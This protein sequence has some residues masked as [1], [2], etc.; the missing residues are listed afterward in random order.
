[1][2]RLLSIFVFG[3]FGLASHSTM[4][5][6]AE[7]RFALVIGNSAYKVGSRPTPV[8]DSGLIAQALKETGFQVTAQNDLNEEQLRKTFGDFAARIGK[9]G[10]DAVA[11]VYFAGNGLQ[12]RGENYLLPVDAGVASV[13]DARAHA[14]SLSEQMHAF[15]ALHLKASIF[16]VDEAGISPS[17]WSGSP[18]AGGFAWVEPEP[19]MLVAFNAAPGTA[20]GEATESAGSYAKV[21]AELIRG[22]SLTPA[23]LFGQVRLRV[24]E[25]TMGAEVPWSAS[26]IPP[27]FVLFARKSDAPARTDR[28]AFLAS[29]R[30]QPL[31]K[32]GVRNAYLV[33]LLRDTLDGYADFLADY[34]QDPMAR[35]VQALLAARREAITWWRSYQRN[36]PEAYWTYLERY[37]NGPHA[38]DAHGLLSRL[39]A[40]NDPPTRFAKL[41]YDVPPPLPDELAY[42]KRPGL[43]LDDPQLA[44]APPPPLPTDVQPQPPQPAM[45]KSPA[46]AAPAGGEPNPGIGPAPLSPLV[47]GNV[48]AALDIT[49][50]IGR[51][52]SPSEK[53]IMPPG[54]PHDVTRGGGEGAASP[55][56]PGSAP[57]GSVKVDQ[58]PVDE[59]S[60]TGGPGPMA[61]ADKAADLAPATATMPIPATPTRAQDRM[62]AALAPSTSLPIPLR[63]PAS[64][65]ARVPVAGV[66]SQAGPAA[67]N[68]SPTAAKP[69]LAPRPNPQ[70]KL[71]VEGAAAPRPPQA[72]GA[73]KPT[74]TR[75]PQSGC[76]DLDG[77]QD[78]PGKRTCR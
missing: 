61:P 47:P 73:A 62:P 50:A 77:R 32:I 49:G 46:S 42:L 15:A 20:I 65:P 76:T 17:S 40:S 28:L 70:P 74:A 8:N 9:G 2:Q 5:V 12:L 6:A 66:P 48:P 4:A 29:L 3:F 53:S 14:V 36:V 34:W 7:M 16:I 26:K 59:R 56:Q 11:V 25:L 63:R 22:D 13:D 35:R 60:A 18:P 37:P 54:S 64:A 44:F 75:Q 41:E 27:Q 57:S 30:G 19:N 78:L 10:P 23:E 33:T 72:I 52:G 68:G 69:V 38:V 58:K 39:G 51:L 67:G 21:L 71:A 24:G 55:S 45:A 31:Q 43:M 1:M